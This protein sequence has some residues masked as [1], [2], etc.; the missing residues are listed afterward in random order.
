MPM[1]K[2]KPEQIVTLLRQVGWNSPTGKPLRKPAKK[3][4]GL[5]ETNDTDTVLQEMSW[6]WKSERSIVR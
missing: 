4:N 3:L 6:N 1:K 5:R 2:Y